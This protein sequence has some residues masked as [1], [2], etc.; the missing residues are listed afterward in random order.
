[1]MMMM[2]M[3]MTPEILIQI[4]D[5]LLIGL[6]VEPRPDRPFLLYKKERKLT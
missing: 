5:I 6:F 4:A 3:M 1:M 2:M